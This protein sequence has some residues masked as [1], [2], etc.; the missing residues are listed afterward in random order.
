MTTYRTGNNW[1]VTIVRE[2]H[3]DP[4]PASVDGRCAE[5]GEIHP[6]CKPGQCRYDQTD[7][8]RSSRL[9]ALAHALGY[10]LAL[11]PREE[12]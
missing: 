5:S 2:A 1:G 6:K 3:D 4:C 7:A 9:F 8:R 10:D 11:I 12:P